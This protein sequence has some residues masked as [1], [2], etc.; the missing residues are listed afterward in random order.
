MPAVPKY[1]GILRHLSA[2]GLLAKLSLE[3]HASRGSLTVN[4]F[5]LVWCLNL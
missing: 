3:V 2:S 5:W 1:L 4:S